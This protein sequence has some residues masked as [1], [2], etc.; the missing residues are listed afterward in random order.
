MR[1]LRNRELDEVCHSLEE[2]KVRRQ[3][4]EQ[5]PHAP[6]TRGYQLLRLATAVLHL[7]AKEAAPGG[8]RHH[9][10]GSVHPSHCPAEE[11]TAFGCQ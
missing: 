11:G 5:A 1:H 7:L 2:D 6:P 8:T 4:I 9:P 3:L 10:A